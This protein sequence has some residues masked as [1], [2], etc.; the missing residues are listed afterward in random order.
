MFSVFPCALR[1]EVIFYRMLQG[2]QQKSTLLFQNREMAL[3]TPADAL[4]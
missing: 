2:M 1:G 3:S 4:T